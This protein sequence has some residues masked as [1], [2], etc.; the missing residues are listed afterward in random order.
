MG[1]LKGCVSNKVSAHANLATTNSQVSNA[2][3]IDESARSK[4]YDTIALPPEVAKISERFR[5]QD[6]S[7]SK[8]LPANGICTEL[9]SLPRTSHLDSNALARILGRHKKTIQKAVRRGELPLPFKFLGKQCWTVG[10]IVDHIVSL[11]QTASAQ[12]QREELRRRVA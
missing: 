4:H 7:R 3:D 8:P 2:Q 9:A 10:V 5:T 1:R 11:Q 12:Q 6:E